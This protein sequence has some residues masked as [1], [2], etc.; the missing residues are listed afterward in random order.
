MEGSK[1]R[2]RKANFSDV[3]LRCLLEGI[4]VE[5]EI[6]NCQL[7]GALT[8]RR[9]KE[10]WERIQV[11]VNAVS[12]GAVRSVDELKTKW[13]QLKTNVLKEQTYQGKTGGGGPMK[14]TPFKDVILTIL[15]D[16]SEVVHGINGMYECYV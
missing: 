10:A 16:R 4:C 3:E 9:K 12:A 7:Q 14:E 1:K 15:G 2:D 8:A 11:Q 13:K 5:K 6:I